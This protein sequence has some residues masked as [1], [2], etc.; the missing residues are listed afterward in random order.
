MAGIK[1][2]RDDDDI[3]LKRVDQRQDNALHGVQIRL[4]PAARWQWQIGVCPQAVADTAI[5]QPGIACR[6]QIGLM[7]RQCMNIGV[8]VENRLRAIAVMHIPIQNE[9]AFCGTGSACCLYRD[10]DI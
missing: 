4:M 2:V 10:A 5:I 9:K 8:G 3:W 1:A 7:Q 6:E